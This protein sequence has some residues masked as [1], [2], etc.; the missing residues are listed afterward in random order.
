MTTV[1]IAD[2]PEATAQ[3]VG[4][5]GPAWELP[6]IGVV[7]ILIGVGLLAIGGLATGIARSFGAPGAYPPGFDRQFVGASIQF[8]TTWASFVLA[9]VL[10]GLMG[11]CWWNLNEWEPEAD[12]AQSPEDR[13]ESEGHL[14]RG[15]GIIVAIQIA[16]VLTSAASIAALVGAILE[17]QR[18]I[19]AW[20]IDFSVGAGTLAVLIVATTGVLRGRRL[21][22]QYSSGPRPE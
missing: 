7:V 15:C 3:D 10:L 6:E 18:P 1:P 22:S 9:A 21:V 20:S 2:E 13:A 5:P 16:L 17:Y 19:V 4:P 14:R 8:G 11:V 12:D